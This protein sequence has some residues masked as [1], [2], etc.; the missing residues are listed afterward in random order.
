MIPKVSVIIPTYGGDD[1]LIR[2]V[3]SVLIQDYDNFEVIVVDDNNPETIERLKTEEI[4]QRF[5]GEKRVK[6]IQHSKNKNGSAARNTGFRNSDGEYI[7]FLDDDDIFLQ[8]KLQSQ[9]AYLQEHTEFGACYCWRRQLG[10]VICGELVG[11]LTES[12]LDLSFTTTTAALMIRRS[13]Y[14]ELNGFDES[15]RRHQD[16]EFLLRFYKRYK[17]GVVKEILIEIIGNG[18]NNNPTGKKLYEIKKQFFDQFGDEIDRINEKKPG[19][20]KYVYAQHF[21]R[22]FKEMIR[23][24]N[25]ILAVKIYFRYGYKGGLEFWKIFLRCCMEG[26]NERLRGREN[27]KN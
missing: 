27:V 15:Y 11:D 5:S 4:M 9:V 17:I 6:Y 7:C 1:T 2:A 23:Y 25:F 26:I 10:E 16:Y 19:Y 12:L 22:A 13:C 21:A 14:E 20:R 8:H 24:G 18:V 3:K